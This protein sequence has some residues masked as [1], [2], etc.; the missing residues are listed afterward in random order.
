V[1]TKQKCTPKTKSQNTPTFTGNGSHSYVST[2][3]ISVT[4]SPHN[5]KTTFDQYQCTNR[6]IPIISRLS[7]HLY[8]YR[9]PVVISYH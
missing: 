6:L 7:M 5:A 1:H 9:L 4:C 8:L 3:D 2:N